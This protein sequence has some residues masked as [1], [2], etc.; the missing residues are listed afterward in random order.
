MYV[1]DQFPPIMHS[2]T[3]FDLPVANSCPTE[4]ENVTTVPKAVSR[5]DAK[6]PSPGLRT[7]QS[8]G[9]KQIFKIK[10]RHTYCFN[11]KVLK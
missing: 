9:R 8:V 3:I 11:K 1:T 7:G 4:Q 10:L 5:L 6:A 2:V